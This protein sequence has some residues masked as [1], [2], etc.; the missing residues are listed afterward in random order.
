MRRLFILICALICLCSCANAEVYAV[1]FSAGAAA[2]DSIGKTVIPAGTYDR[3]FTLRND[4]GELTGYAAGID[5]EYGVMY[6]VLN[7]DGLPLSDHKYLSVVSA[8]EGCIVNE[9]GVYRYL[10][11]AHKY[12]EYAYSNMNYAGD[13]MIL[14]LTG[15]VH[16]DIGDAIS[17]L[18]ADGISFRTGISILGNIGEVSE[19]LIPL[20]DSGSN[21]YGY[22]NNQ[23]SWVIKPAFKYAAPFLNGLAVIAGS[24]GYGVIDTDGRVRLAP[25]S[26]QIARSGDIFAMIRGNSLR[27]YDSELVITS[28]T[29]LNGA[30]VNLTGEYIVVSGD[31]SEAVFDVYGTPLFSRPTGAQISSVGSG[32]FIVRDGKWGE[33]CVELTW[34]D[35]ST[36]SEPCNSIYFL[37]NTRLAYALMTESDELKYGLMS[38]DG[39]F[40]TEAIYDSLAV[41]TDGL[42]CADVSDGAV[43]IDEN[44]NVLNTFVTASDSQN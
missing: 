24:N 15:N 30:H 17:I 4:D 25:S 2:V 38:I 18:W 26:L 10:S 33:A 31:D 8:G 27:V 41:V 7:S 16:D 28:I 32:A 23:G 22:I 37:D 11:A 5:T 34:L 43:I 44:G 19:G 20:Y 12:D 21:L 35:G 13:G 1:N 9:G 42:Y 29:P 40:V 36:L 3:L 39:N 14:A 6:A